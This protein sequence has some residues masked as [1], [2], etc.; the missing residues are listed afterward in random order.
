MD[1]FLSHNVT[2]VAV[3]DRA[4]DDFLSQSDSS[5]AAKPSIAHK[6]SHS[7]G[8]FTG[9]FGGGSSKKAEI[10]TETELSAFVLPSPISS[11]SAS[12]PDLVVVMPSGPEPEAELEVEIAAAGPASVVD[13]PM[14][15]VSAAANA[16]QRLAKMTIGRKAKP[17]IPY[18]ARATTEAAKPVARPAGRVNLL[19]VP[20]TPTTPTFP[21]PTEPA[22]ASEQ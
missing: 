16:W 6:H 20:K 10:E 7:S 17:I 18:Y 1:D 14:P 12:K 21:E 13:V 5:D 4:M 3:T 8:F 9:L 15:S 2:A 19:V 22:T 11:P